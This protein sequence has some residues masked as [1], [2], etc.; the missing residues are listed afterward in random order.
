[1][2]QGVIFSVIGARPHFVKAAP[3]MEA[4][5]A[6]DQ[7]VFTIHTG[8]HY[9]HN[10]SDVFFAELGMPTPGPLTSESDLAP[11]LRRRRPS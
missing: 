1:M 10:M 9:D 11:M 7:T 3:F 2:T 5:Q 4:M 6:S 8:Q